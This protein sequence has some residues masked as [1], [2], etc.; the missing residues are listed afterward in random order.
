MKTVIEKTLKTGKRVAVEPLNSKT[1]MHAA[2]AAGDATGFAGNLAFLNEC[3]KM[4]LR[5]INGV[6]V[7]YTSLDLD[8]HFTMSEIR[9]LRA[10]FNEIN[11]EEQ[12]PLEGAVVK[13]E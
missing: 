7:D 1:E 5:S 6:T 11:V 10:I 8:E 9:E 3:V 2:K 12:I 4:T 13:V